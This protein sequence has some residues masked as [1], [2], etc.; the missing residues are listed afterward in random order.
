MVWIKAQLSELSIFKKCLNQMSL[1]ASKQGY[2]VMA[3]CTI[4]PQHCK[5]VPCI[6]V[7]VFFKKKAALFLTRSVASQLQSVFHVLSCSI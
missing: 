7:C 5:D 1:Q 2:K 4:C 3:L 6:S